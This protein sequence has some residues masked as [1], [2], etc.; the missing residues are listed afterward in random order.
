M[1]LITLALAHFAAASLLQNAHAG[2]SPY[3]LDY[4]DKMNGECTSSHCIDELDRCADG[5]DPECQNRLNCIRDAGT[6]NAGSCLKQMKWSQLDD[7]EVKVLDCAHSNKCM[8]NE[9][10]AQSSFLELLSKEKDERGL[11]AET[12]AAM[13]S[14]EKAA[15]QVVA[16]HLVYLEK[17]E[18][19]V[20]RTQGMMDEVLKDKSMGLEEKIEALHM[21]TGHLSL[22]Q[23]SAKKTMEGMGMDTSEFDTEEHEEEEEDELENKM[24]QA[25]EEEEQDGKPDAKAA[26]KAEVKKEAKVEKKPA[27]KV[28]KKP[29]A[30]AEKKPEAKVEKKPT[31]KEVSKPAPK[32]A[33][34]KGALVE[35]DGKADPH[36]RTMED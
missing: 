30:K 27:A 31:A 10:Q 18:E 20:K 17:T 33:A 3:V 13:T 16:A 5:S 25:D 29:E 7:T 22:L 19:M 21:L 2:P 15:L 26:K 36:L 4:I 6:S 11:S 23:A 14:E 8:P 24:H 9:W 28:E 35:E 34:K 32:P 1:A 12:S